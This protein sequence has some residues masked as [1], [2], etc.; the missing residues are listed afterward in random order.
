MYLKEIYEDVCSLAVSSVC[1]F[2]VVKEHCVFHIKLHRT[3]YLCTD[4]C[5]LSSIFYLEIS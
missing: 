3:L 1:T 2:F 4:I 5:N